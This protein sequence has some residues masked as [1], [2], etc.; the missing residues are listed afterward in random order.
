MN[1]VDPNNID[2]SPAQYSITGTIMPDRIG[3]RVQAFA[4]SMPIV[5]RRTG[6]ARQLLGE[7]I[8]GQDGQFQIDYISIQLRKDEMPFSNGRIGNANTNISFRVFDRARQEL[9]I[10]CIKALDHRLDTQSIERGRR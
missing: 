5:E 1:N 7:A 10:K 9:N 4:R 6:S 8:A 2:H 3:I